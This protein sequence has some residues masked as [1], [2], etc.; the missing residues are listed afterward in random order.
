MPAQ[1]L[2]PHYAWRWRSFSAPEASLP[3]KFR[4]APARLP[5]GCRAILFCSLF[6]TRMVFFGSVRGRAEPIQRLRVHHLWREEGLPHPFIN[7]LLE[8]R[9]GIYEEPSE[10]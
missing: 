10:V 8:T 2:L 7:Q 4:C 1:R 9:R 3:N 6:E 5:T